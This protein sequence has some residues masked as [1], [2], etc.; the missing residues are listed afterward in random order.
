MPLVSREV[1]DILTESNLVEEANVYG[2]QIPNNLNGRAGM[3]ALVLK[4]EQRA[5]V[6]Q[7]M[8]ELG[9]FCGKGLPHY[10]VPR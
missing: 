5:R 4:P 1:R 3:A 10:A 6:E 9:R 8:L 2:V 7:A